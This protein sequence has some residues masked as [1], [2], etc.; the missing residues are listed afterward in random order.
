MKL[1]DNQD[2]GQAYKFGR[3]RIPAVSEYFIRSEL[4][5]NTENFLIDLQLR[6]GSVRQGSKSTL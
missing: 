3:A 1:V 6:K 4:P 5:F 2:T